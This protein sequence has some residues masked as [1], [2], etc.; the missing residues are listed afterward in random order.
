MKRLIVIIVLFSAVTAFGQLP[1]DFNCNG[2]A[3]EVGDVIFAANFLIGD[4]SSHDLAECQIENGDI[5]GDGYPLTFSDCGFLFYIPGDTTNPPPDF[6]RHPE[7]DTLSI[8]SEFALPGESLTLPVHFSSVD[9]II[10]FQL[11]IISDPDYITLDSVVIIDDL[12]RVQLNCAG[13]VSALSFDYFGDYESILLLPCDYYIGDL[14]A[15]VNSDI[16]QPVTTYIEFSNDPEHAF[17]TGLANLAFFEPVTVDAEIT[18]MPTGIDDYTD[19]GLPSKISIIAYPNPFNGA[20]NITAITDSE[21]ELVIYDL[22]GREIRSFQIHIGNN[23]IIWDGFD[24]NGLA[25]RSGLYFVRINSPFENNV[26]KIL[27]LK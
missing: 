20:V 9:T 7:Q 22:L 23:N 26:K 16:S 1:G 14:Y 13:N 3:Y 11:Y 15:S 4:C 10:A 21:S 18:I 2:F 19:T 17:Y 27:L 8:A 24:E 25:V 5:D 12:Q 6:P